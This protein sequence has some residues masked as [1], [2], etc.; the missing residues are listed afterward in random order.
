P[1]TWAGSEQGYLDAQSFPIARSAVEPAGRA[2]ATGAVS[3]VTTV[4]AGLRDEPWRKAALASDFLSV[5][6]IPLDYSDL[7]HGVLTVYAAE[8]DAFDET[9]EAVLGELGETIASAISASERKRALLTTS[10]TR[11][12]YAVSDRS[13]VLT[14]LA[15]AADCSLSYE[16]GVQQTASGNYVFVTV[17]DAAVDDV[18]DAAAGLVVVDDVQRIRG[19]EAGGVVRL[20]LSKPFLATELA[21]HGAILRTASA[22]GSGANLTI[23][24]P[25]SV[26][27]RHVTGFLRERFGEVELT[28]KQT[29]EQASEHG[30]YASVLERLTDR[31]LEVLETA[32]YSGF[33]ETPRG[34]TGEE[35]ADS[36]GISPQAFYQH[37]RTVQRKLFAALIDDHAPVATAHAG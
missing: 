33:F 7:S 30:F 26:D 1:R 18:V 27:T 31:Q 4:A 20:Q 15:G 35:V 6:S 17:E 11:V 36:L 16:G 12:D 2:A 29:R 24:V 32:Y 28:A 8:Q 14:Q 19:G 37:V 25:G 9:V 13:F 22:T 10:M 23:D 3:M 34:V 21:D 5:L